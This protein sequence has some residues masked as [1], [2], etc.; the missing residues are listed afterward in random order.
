[1]TILYCKKRYTN[2]IELNGI[3]Y[4]NEAENADLD[5]HR[6]SLNIQ[7]DS[8]LGGIRVDCGD[9]QDRLRT[10]EDRQQEF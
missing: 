6:Q 7:Y 2:T 9:E 10:A 1:M 8:D 4:N 5:S 3:L